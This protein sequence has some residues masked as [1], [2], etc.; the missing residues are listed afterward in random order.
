MYTHAC[1]QDVSIS[2]YCSVLYKW[3]GYYFEGKPLKS[4]SPSIQRSYYQL[5]TS[6]PRSRVTDSS[7]TAGTASLTGAGAAHS[8]LYQTGTSKQ[9]GAE[10][11]GKPGH[12]SLISETYMVAAESQPCQLS[13]ELHT[14]TRAHTISLCPLH[15]HP[16]LPQENSNSCTYFLKNKDKPYTNSCKNVVSFS[17]K[18]FQSISY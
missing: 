17:F 13:P 4:H 2:V 16:P 7:L 12:L 8:G 9:D 14:C 15:H 10:G 11:K 6:V 3:H 18:T 5:H 1:T